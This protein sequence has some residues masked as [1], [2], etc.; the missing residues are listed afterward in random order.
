MNHLAYQFT[1]ANNRM[2]DKEKQIENEEL[3]KEY[4]MRNIPLNP[5][6]ESSNE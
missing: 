4:L 5:I 6:L 3:K 2:I 1:Q